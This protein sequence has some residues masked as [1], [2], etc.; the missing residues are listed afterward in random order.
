PAA[1]VQQSAVSAPQTASQPLPP[2][3]RPVLSKRKPAAQAVAQRQSA[4]SAPQAAPQ[5]PPL[6]EIQE[7]VQNLQPP[8]PGKAARKQ[9]DKTAVVKPWVLKPKGSAGRSSPAGYKIQSAM[10]LADNR[11]LYN[12]FCEAARLLAIEHL[13]IKQTIREQEKYKISMVLVKAQNMFPY[14]Q[15]FVNNW[16]FY[17]LIAQYLR[18]RSQYAHAKDQALGELQKI[19]NDGTGDNHARDDGEVTNLA[20]KTSSAVM[21]LPLARNHEQPRPWIKASL[22]LLPHIR[23]R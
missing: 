7:Q 12:A 4:V 2:A 19:I 21:A 20:K 18:N 1:Q 8:Q 5:P 15:R 13:D 6:D 22:P 10:G 17:D 16:P 14:L 3:S 9:S 11:R 23:E